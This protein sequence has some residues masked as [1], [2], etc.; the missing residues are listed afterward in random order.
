VSIEW[1]RTLRTVLAFVAGLAVATPMI[2]GAIGVS[3]AV[4]IG[5]TVVAVAATITRVMM[6][7]EI[8]EWING[9]LTR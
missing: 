6:I 7:P 8:D 3:T 5:A 9:K 1:V 4:G 2:L